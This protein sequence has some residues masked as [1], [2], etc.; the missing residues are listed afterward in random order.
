MIA[1]R[2]AGLALSFSA[3][4]LASAAP[5]LAQEVQ[6]VRPG[7]PGEAPAV[8]SEEEA[9]Q[10]ARVDY[11]P[12]DI[13]FMQ[14][15]IVHHQQA[16]EMAALVGGR[17]GDEVITTAAGRIDASQQDEI[18][19]MREWLEG[20]GQPAEMAGM[21]HMHHTGMAGMASPAQMEELAAARGVQFDRLF[22]QLMI[23]HHEGA[24]TMV[25]ELLEL[26]GTATDPVLYDFTS[27]IRT[28]QQAEIDRMKVAL[29][30]LSDDP[31]TLLGAGLFDAGESISNLRHVAFLPSRRASSIRPTPRA[32]GLRCRPPLLKPRQGRLP[33]P[34]LLRPMLLLRAHP[35]SAMSSAADCLAL[36]IPTWPFRAI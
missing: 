17:T 28:D 15:M 6:I 5:A 12:A 20:Y 24:L 8:L 19:F 35:G 21:G 36:P 23:R 11:L 13:A 16:V 1:H 30:A 7:A 26:Q 25:E 31:R 22:L 10:L 2:P 3:L 32:G 29:A 33:P 9:T 14:G 27:D 18:R 4:L 34:M